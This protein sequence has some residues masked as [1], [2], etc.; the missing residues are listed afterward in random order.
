MENK[1]ID[2]EPRAA[3]EMQTWENIYNRV[4]SRYK[5]YVSYPTTTMQECPSKAEINDKLTH[6]C[7][8]DSNELAD[9]NSITLNFYERNELTSD[10]LAE[11]WPHNSTTQI[12]IQLRHVTT[13]V[14]N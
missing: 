1:T 2:T 6:A 14:L 5:Q 3:V 9:Y 4:P 7:T 12:D 13:I 10:S 11:N 8:T